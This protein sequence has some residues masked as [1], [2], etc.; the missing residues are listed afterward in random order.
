MKIVSSLH[1]I[2]TPLSFPN[3]FNN[4]ESEN[5]SSKS[6]AL[7]LLDEKTFLD[8]TKSG[9]APTSRFDGYTTASLG[10]PFFDKR[11][12]ISRL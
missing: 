7:V 11:V 12:I 10:R 2:R 6:R 5:E 4:D 3:V 8:Y 1:S 9:A